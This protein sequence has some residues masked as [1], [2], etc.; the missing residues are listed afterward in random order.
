MVEPQARAVTVEQRLV[1]RYGESIRPWLAD[2]PR[3]LE[4]LA[5][6]WD[7][8]LGEAFADGNSAVTL[9]ASRDGVP[10]VLKVSPDPVILAKQVT[11]M[12]LQGTRAPEILETA[13]GAVLMERVDGE[14]RWPDPDRFAALLRDL[15]AVPDPA[16]HARAD[17]ATGVPGF[18]P[19]FTPLGPVTAEHLRRARA[20]ADD[21]IATQGAPVLLHGDLHRDNLLDAGPRGVVV[22]DPQGTLGEPEFDA[23][24]Y[25]LGKSD[26]AVRLADLISVTSLSPERLERWCRSMAPLIAIGQLRLGRPIAH[27]Q[28]YLDEL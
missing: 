8:S 1:R 16:R 18:F 21:L 3:V 15:H 4:R 19:R 20:L 9:R 7:L 11:L 5:A 23:V 28:H 6:S 14:S 26:V 17:L 10:L 24:D 12:R 2:L 27:L 25:V 22:L 13:E